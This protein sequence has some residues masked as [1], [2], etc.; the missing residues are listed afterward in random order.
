MGAWEDFKEGFENGLRNSTGPDGCNDGPKSC[1][2]C[3]IWLV[4]IIMLI[5]VLVS[6]GVNFKGQG[7]GLPWDPIRES[8]ATE[9][10]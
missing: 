6:L 9:G 2:E 7:S 5:F 4:V 10:L 1:L 8:P 3:F